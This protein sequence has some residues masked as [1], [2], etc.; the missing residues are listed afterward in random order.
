MEPL[1]KK[2]PGN[3]RKGI[4]LLIIS[5][6][7]GNELTPIHA[8]MKFTENVAVF[9]GVKHVTVMLGVNMSGLKSHTREMT[10][11]STMD[12]NRVLSNEPTVDS[13]ELLKEQI[14]SHDMIIDIHSSPSCTEFALIDIDEYAHSM[15]KW[16]DLANLK[17]AF[18]YSSSNTIK[19]YCLEK[20]KPALTLEVNKLDTIDYKSSKRCV[21]ILSKLVSL[22]KFVTLNQAPPTFP[23][24]Q[25]IKTYTEGLLSFHLKNGDEIKIGTTLFSLIDLNGTL[26]HT[27]LSQVEGY[28]VCE[29]SQHYIS[30][31][32]YVMLIQPNY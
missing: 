24:I 18:R 31:G 19:R 22:A 17:C 25:E 5:G 6:A 13:I 4:K 12:L 9:M 16:C 26:V 2:I 23:E 7:H 14:E 10:S 32:E 11:S 29:P 3:K 28:V 27:E 20:G 15:K 30:R 21:D 1:I 8:A